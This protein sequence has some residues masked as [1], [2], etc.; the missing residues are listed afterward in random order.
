MDYQ[1]I[2]K[3]AFKIVWHNRFMWLLGLLTG[4]VSTLQS[5][6]NYSLDNSDFEKIK[7]WHH[8]IPSGDNIAEA[9]AKSAE[10][11]LG[12]SLFSLM[13]SPTFRIVLVVILLLVIILIYLHFTARGAI[14]KSASKLNDGEKLTLGAAWKHGERYFWRVFIFNLVVTAIILLILSILVTPIILLAIFGLS[15][16]AIILGLLLAILFLLFIIYLAFIAPY[17]ERILVLENKRA[18]ES[19]SLG[20]KFFNKHWKKILVLYLILFTIG[21]IAV[22]AMAIILIVPS[23]ILIGLGL[24][25]YTVSQ[26]ATFIYAFLAVIIILIL[27]FVI[28][29]LINSFSSTAYT[30]GY[31]ELKKTE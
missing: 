11:V 21:L 27:F 29:G 3:K 10:R 25:I 19:I 5:G 4:G 2:I 1:N 9:S 6:S 30:L 20:I 22:T 31:L 7:N 26:T 23:L 18:L 12:D 8:I 17:A 14:I 28:T 13:S 15:I 24:I 16:A